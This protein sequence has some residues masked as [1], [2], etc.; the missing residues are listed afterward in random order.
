MPLCYLRGLVFF[1]SL[2][3]QCLQTPLRISQS[4][5][6]YSVSTAA[7]CLLLCTPVS[8]QL[9]QERLLGEGI[10]SLA[11][12]AQSEGDAK[13]GAAVFYQS[14]FGCVRCHNADA[15]TAA[16]DSPMLGPDLTGIDRK[17][18]AQE[19][20]ESILTPSKVIKK[21]FETIT[22]VLSDGRAVVGL[23]V[24]QSDSELILRNPSDGSLIS[25]KKDAVESKSLSPTSIM[26]ADIANQLGS[27]QQF[28]DLVR[29][30]IEIRDGGSAR[31]R[32][33]KPASTQ[34]ALQLP[35]YESHVDHAGL[36]RSLDRRSLDRGRAI[37]ERLCVNCHGTQEREGSLPTSLRFA[38]GT[39]KNGSDPFSMYQTLTRGFGLMTP[40][41]WMVPQQKYDVI[42]YIREAY[43]RRNNPSQYSQLTKEYLNRLPQGDTRGPPPQLIEPWA[44]MDYGPSLIN[45]YEVGADGTNFAHKG[46]AVRLDPGSGGVSRGKAWMVFDHDTMRM[47]AAWTGSGFIDWNWVQFNG[48]HEVHPRLVGDVLAANP[49]GPGWADPETGR[50]EDDKRVVGRDGRRY[51]PLPR[52]WARYRGLYHSGDQ[53]TIAYTIGQTDV[54]ESPGVV[55]VSPSPSGKASGS[56][57]AVFTR[58]LDFGQRDD[59]LLLL[60]ATHQDAGAR[61]ES[62][63][64]A[65]RFGKPGSGANLLAGL[66]GDARGAEWLGQGNRLCLR[67]PAGQEPLRLPIW[68]TRE[69][70]GWAVESLLSAV[71]RN[72][73]QSTNG[74]DKATPFADSGR[75]T[76]TNATLAGGPPKWPQILTT[77]VVAGDSSGPFAVDVLTHPVANPWL[78]QMRFTGLDFYPEGDR[79]VVCTWD[80]DVWLVSGLSKLANFGA[81]T[82]NAAPVK[83]SWQR[84]A[85][86]LFQPLGIKIVDGKIFVT[87]RDQL[88]ILRDLNGDG[89]TDFYDCFNNDHQVTEHFHEFAMGLQI[90]ARGNF[91]YAK[92]A[93][94][95]LPAI[96]PHHGT[97]LR[98]LADGARTDILATGFRAANGVCLNPDGTFVVTDQEGH[99][100]PKNRINWVHEGGFYGNMFGYH[101]VTDSSDEAMEQPLCW[102][103]NEFDRSPAELLWTPKDAWGPLGGSLLNLSYGYGKVFVVPFED[104]GGHKQGGM[105]AL[106]IDPLPTGLI[107]GR[108]HPQD[109]QLYTCGMFAWAGSVTQPGGLYRIRY[110][111]RAMHLPVGLRVKRGKL[112]ITFSDPLDPIAAANPESYSLKTWSLNR[113]AEYGSKHY[114]EKRLPVESATVSDD[115]RTV[116]LGLPD[117]QPTWG[118]EIVCRLKDRD[119]KP[120]E[121][122]IHNSIFKLGE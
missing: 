94:H 91:Y 46:I 13:H 88:V 92:S 79:A 115:G 76:Q 107:R 52:S 36:L 56:E 68:F 32:E 95:A 39:F 67:I 113:T 29:Y 104:V 116:T 100:N 3:V 61:L 17:V 118:M 43:L 47:A 55:F 59:D 2:I 60:V 54:L 30:L 83:L 119:G 24:K 19:L 6:I 72:E 44:T 120:L 7:I 89:E 121:R 87:C 40:Q 12:A 73:E 82:T 15:A 108:F 48:R 106:P 103:T 70:K 102:I 34:I 18:T 53:V 110:T 63:A 50:F 101:N 41:T 74:H 97:L 35:E 51:G 21:G 77:E 23:L 69:T 25:L 65:V 58:T 93:R 62:L 4:N 117:L 33:L 96:V 14:A 10:E 112:A 90:D 81:S 42:H 37:Y 26:P 86:G 11:K 27:R 1:Q 57:V 49:T 98:V 16:A 9:L 111:G 80:G 75:A 22:A 85:S 64:G 31:A 8:A 28:L 71:T 122:K 84:I 45:T 78:A 99:W 20:I 114:G 38:S 105:C 5:L 109:R 66:I